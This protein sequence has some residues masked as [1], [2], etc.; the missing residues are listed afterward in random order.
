MQTPPTVRFLDRTTPPH[1]VTLVL[2]SGMTALTMNIFL[3]SLPTMTA[4]FDTEYRVIQLSVSLYL[5]VNAVLQV[6]IGPISDRLGRRPVLL[7]AMLIFILATLGTLLATSVEM[8]LLFRMGQAVVVAGI[9]LSRA[10][11]RD[12]VDEARSASMIGYV[13]MGMAL[14]PMVG[15]AIGG[16][17]DEAFGWQAS[18]LVLLGC[19]LA[20][21]ALAWADMGETA[22]TRPASLRAQF[23]Q[24]PELLTSRRFWGYCAAA[25]FASGAF[26]AYLGG[27]S[28]VGSTVYG[29][30]PSR[31]GLFFGAP[32]LGY[33]IGNFFSGR[34]SVRMGVNRM[35]LWGCVLSLFGLS[36]MT[37]LTLL[38]MDGPAVFFGLFIFVAVGNGMSLPNATAGMLSVRPRLAG[39]AAGLGGAITIG[40]GAALSALAGALLVPG[41]GALPLVLI[42]W[43][44]AVLGLVSI[45]YVIARER[46]LYG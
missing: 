21:L 38:E 19:G 37:V 6:F 20:I 11:V 5:L 41:S 45:L 26:F 46:R 28:F 22:R 31:L 10:A 30:S 39:T 14:V 36:L 4:W 7:A 17:L 2:L 9:V 13:T 44:T 42:M 29:L 18:F 35:V 23:A 24:Y 40:I 43:V 12:M 27:A 16:L 34:F 1:I 15:P 32:A 33:A 25:G 3:P 8:F